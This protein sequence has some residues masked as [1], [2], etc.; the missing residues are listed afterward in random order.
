MEVS[1][2]CLKQFV[3]LEGL[4][5]EEIAHGFTFAG[6]EV[7]GVRPLAYGT[8]LC[9]GQ[10]VSS[11]PI[12]GTHL[13][14]CQINLGEKYG[15][16]QIVC[17]APN[18]RTG[19]KVIVALD[20]CELLSG[21]ISKSTI[22]GVESNGMCC[23]L[24]E[25]GLDKKY[26]KEEEY[27]GIAELSPLAPVGEENVLHYLL[28]DDY[29]LSLSVLANRPDLLSV[30]NCAK[31]IGAIFNRNVT[32]PSVKHHETFHSDFKVSSTTPLC[33]QFAGKEVKGIK[34]GES[35]L[36]MQRYL[37]AMG[38]RSIDNIVDIGNYVMLITGQPLHMYDYDKLPEKKL[39]ASSDYKGS[40]TALDTKAYD[41]ISGDICICSNNRPM[42]LGGVMGSLE[43][44]VD[45][46]SENI[47][48]EA[49]SF[50][51]VTIRHTS[52]RLG[53]SSESSSRFIKGTN[54]FQWEFVLDYASELLKEY[55]SASSF[56]QTISYES[57]KYEP[58]VIETTYSEINGRL[59][60]NLNKEEIKEA[61]T[62]LNFKISDH[63]E[64]FTCE[65]PPYRLDIET[66]EDLSEEVIRL[67]GYDRIP[68]TLPH[69]A[70]SVGSLGEEE[71]KIQLIENYLTS[72]GLDECLTYTLES[73]KEHELF[74]TFFDSD[75]YVIVNP[76]T[77]DREV[78]RT[79]LS[80]SLL[81]CVSYNLSRQAKDLALFEI[82]E[83]TTKNSYKHHLCV[84][85][86]NNKHEQGLLTTRGYDFYDL[87]GILE[88]I[89]D[90]LGIESNRYKFVEN[91]A[92]HELHPGKSAL[93]QVAGKS[94]GYLG[95]L[96]PV[97]SES[98][99]FGKNKVL[100]MEVDLDEI[101]ALRVSVVKMEKPSKYPTISHDLALIVAKDVPVG[102]LIHLITA[103][104]GGIV[105]D[106][107]VFD[108]YQGENI[109]PNSKSVAISITYG[110]DSHTLE[111]KEVTQVEDN[112]K[113][114]LNKRFKA[115]LRS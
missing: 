18:V 28:L 15:T 87:K 41:V 81:K 113:F 60:T 111:D 100:L 2:N 84:T 17:G 110:S 58:K 104:G 30:L 67:L 94:I 23:S 26:L 38:V 65:V 21:K 22:R 71:E 25:L 69:F 27:T 75:A 72:I 40:F 32:L 19:L 16:K 29:V 14:V 11:E 77:D 47:V 90:T 55:A 46:T 7:E 37:M 50:S 45:L 12:E 20:G 88:G 61:L 89:F 68:S 106:V 13:H 39:T 97:T 80:N 99:D 1:L 43:C 115:V 103:T 8:K 85:L 76:L 59:G 86:A 109:A 91:D 74:S 6:V 31:E 34:T 5:V 93:L 64:K 49:A 92:V 3:D 95:E 51:P 24:L 66:W 52:Q 53:L 33:P 57:E 54:H 4:S 35:P 98:Y 56:S 105:R 44:A 101:L 48:I 9:I 102:D 108:V 78:V 62:R 83:V 36:W 73:K 10:V 114:E 63:G 70:S 107:N 79:C 96:H 82:S 112:I 42:C